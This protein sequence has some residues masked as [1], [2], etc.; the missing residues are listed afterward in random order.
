MRETAWDNAKKDSP[1]GIVRDPK[2]NKP[3]NKDDPW[4]MG[5]KPGLEHRKHMKSA[6]K[7]NLTRTEFLDEFNNP[8]HYRPELP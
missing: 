7:R 1:D 5:H 4:D 2:T 6:E 8:S 3:L